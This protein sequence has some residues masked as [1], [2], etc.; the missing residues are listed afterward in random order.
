[1]TAES[2]MRLI[3]KTT[4]NKPFQK[5]GKILNVLNHGEKVIFRRQCNETDLKLE[6][7]IRRCEIE[8]CLKILSE[9]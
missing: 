8:K 6:K 3:N 5:I 2:E 1:M 7:E 4:K 9:M